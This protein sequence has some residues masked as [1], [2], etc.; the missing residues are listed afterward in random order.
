[1]TAFL[2]CKNMAERHRALT[3][4]LAGSY[5]EAASVCLGRYHVPPVE[6]VLEDNQARSIVKIDWPKV[7]LRE[8][9]A[10]AN[11]DDAIRDGAYVLAIAAVEFSRDLYAV[12][13]A[14]TRTGADYYIASADADLTDLESWFRLGVSG[15]GLGQFEA[16]RRMKLKAAQTKRGDSNLPAIVS[17]VGFRVG[18]ILIQTVVD[19][20]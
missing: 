6:F 2:N 5:F 4:W 9:E 18:L 14:E 8:K 15:T 16:R 20:L 1:M 11:Q 7:S 3:P 17:I 12:R 10:W 13:R 19:S